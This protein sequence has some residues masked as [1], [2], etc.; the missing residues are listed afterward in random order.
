MENIAVEDLRQASFNK[1]PVGSGPFQFISLDS[2]A[3]LD[4]IELKSFAQYYDKEP[5]IN[6]LIVSAYDDKEKLRKNIDSFDGIRDLDAEILQAYQDDFNVRKL[7]LP[8]YEALIFNLGSKN[9]SN[10][11]LRE[12]LR[13]SLNKDDLVDDLL[14]EA[15]YSPIPFFSNYESVYDPEKANEIFEEAGYNFEEG[16]EFRQDKDGNILEFSLVT[17]D[18]TQKTALAK[19]LQ[20]LWAAAGVKVNLIMVDAG[21]LNLEF[22]NNRNYD[23]LLIGQNL[24]SDLDLYSFWHSSQAQNGQNLSQIRSIDIDILIEKIRKTHD[25]ND[26]LTLSR[27]LAD[28]ILKEVPA[29]FLYTPYYTYAIGKNVHDPFIPENLTV[30]SDR[31]ALINEWYV[32][33]KRVWK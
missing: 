9:L 32:K 13:L 25:H 29:I 26:Q 11:T 24:G 22:L 19:K 16:E 7:K 18:N 33:E 6:R 30:P 10:K 2:S 28:E 4:R 1:H 31:Y 23:S 8:R 12:A 17:L 15:V 14:G 21:T 3:S 20:E 27:Q 5:Y